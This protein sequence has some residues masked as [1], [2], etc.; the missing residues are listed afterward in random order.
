MCIFDVGI[1]DGNDP[2][3]KKFMYDNNTQ[4]VLMN[5]VKLLTHIKV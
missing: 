5:D 1:F 3:T 2:D 4:D